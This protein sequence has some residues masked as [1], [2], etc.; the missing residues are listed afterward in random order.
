MAIVITADQVLPLSVG[1]ARDGEGNL[2]PLDGFPT[3]ESSDPTVAEV[4]DNGDG[5]ATVVSRLA[6]NA[7]VTMRA[8]ALVGDGV[9]EVLATLDVTVVPG[10]AVAVTIAAGVPQSKE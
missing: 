3:F 9:I 5:T 2:A 10:Q 4:V 8:D 6:G 1:Q 7:Q